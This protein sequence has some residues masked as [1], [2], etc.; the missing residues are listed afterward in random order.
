MSTVNKTSVREELDG[1]KGQFEQLCAA[2]K[3]GQEAKALVVALLALLELL[4][5]VLME[6]HTVKNSRNSSRPPSQMDKPDETAT[7][8]GSHTKG[9]DYHQGHARHT[10]TIETVQIAPVKDCVCCS[11]DLTAIPCQGYERRTV[12]DIIFETRRH[13]SDAEIKECPECL[14]LNKGVFPAEMAGPLQ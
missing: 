12:V 5:A 4:M 2:G 14:T 11:K 3:L 9:Q 13:H 7:Q 1:L 6:K 8:P 10:R